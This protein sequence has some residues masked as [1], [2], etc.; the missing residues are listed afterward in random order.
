MVH[1]A[2][3][4]CFSGWSALKDSPEYAVPSKTEPVTPSTNPPI[5]TSHIS[6]DPGWPPILYP[7]GYHLLP[8]SSLQDTQRDASFPV[9]GTG[10]ARQEG[11]AAT[12]TATAERTKPR[13]PSLFP[14]RISP[15]LTTTNQLYTTPSILRLS[16]PSPSLTSPH[17]QK[18][19]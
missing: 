1:T 6:R 10:Q 13:P 9:L 16:S 2:Q 12:A 5:L 3:L 17:A 7:I 8:P 11:A 14:T 18:S 4:H 15:S 19:I